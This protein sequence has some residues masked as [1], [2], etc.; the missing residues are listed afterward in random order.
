MSFTCHVIRM[1]LVCTRMSS[2]CHSYVLVCHP[3]VTRMYLYVIRIS[4]GFAMNLISLSYQTLGS[5]KILHQKWSFPFR[6]VLVNMITVPC[7]FADIYWKSLERILT[8]KEL[9]S[10]M[11]LPTVNVF[12]F[13]GLEFLLSHILGLRNLRSY[14]TLCGS[15]AIVQF[16][17]CDF[18]QYHSF[19][20]FK[21][22]G[23]MILHYA[24][25]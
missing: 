18:T 20:A 13:W 24:I 3:Y 1:L 11:K 10:R 5:F 25:H 6:I 7:G 19:T 17:E 14:F 9:A 4:I 23:W 2:L 22:T 21:F 8:T 16:T 12:W 15:L